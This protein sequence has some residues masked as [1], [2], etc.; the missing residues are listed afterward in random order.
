MCNNKSK[1]ESKLN[2]GCKGY[3]VTE[4]NNNGTN[5]NDNIEVKTVQPAADVPGPS[6]IDVEGIYR[7]LKV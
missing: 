1:D 5:D 6:W 3:K 2:S 4:I 7:G